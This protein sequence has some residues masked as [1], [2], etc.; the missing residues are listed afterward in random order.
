MS[1]PNHAGTDL[2][3]VMQTATAKD[4]AMH[5]PIGVHPLASRNPAIMAGWPSKT[6]TMDV[7]TRSSPWSIYRLGHLQVRRHRVRAVAEEINHESARLMV[8]PNLHLCLRHPLLL[9][10]LMD[11]LRRL[12]VPHQL[13]LLPPL[14]DRGEEDL[15]TRTILP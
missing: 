11:A 8:P 12:I 14:T 3:A 6:P 4:H 2:L 1:Q 5:P 13:D 10:G 15:M 9:V 7:S